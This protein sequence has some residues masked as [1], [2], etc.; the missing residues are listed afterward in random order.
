M[1]LRA[2]FSICTKT[3]PRNIFSVKVCWEHTEHMIDATEEFLDFISES[4]V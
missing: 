3:F 1:L 2:E 4:D